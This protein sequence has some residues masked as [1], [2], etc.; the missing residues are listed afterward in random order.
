MVLTEVVKSEDLQ[1][2][3]QEAKDAGKRILAVSPSRLTKVG[4][5]ATHFEVTSFV[6]VTQ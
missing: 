2:K 3:I 4:R 6:L 5:I 1:S